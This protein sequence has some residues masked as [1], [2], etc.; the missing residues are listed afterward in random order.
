MISVLIIF[1]G[2]PT[3]LN[4]A[5]WTYVATAIYAALQLVQLL[6]MRGDR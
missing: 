4:A 1:R 2:F 3:L 5:A 6:L